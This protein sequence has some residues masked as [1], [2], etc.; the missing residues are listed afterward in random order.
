MPFLR[1]KVAPPESSEPPEIATFAVVLETDTST[2][3]GSDCGNVP[4]FDTVSEEPLTEIWAEVGAG[5]G[6]G[7][8]GGLVSLEAVTPTLGSAG[9]SA[10]AEDVAAAMRACCWNGSLLEKRSNVTS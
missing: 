5:A 8:G 1:V 7:G 9:A 4:P 10:G 3:T 6:G 2:N